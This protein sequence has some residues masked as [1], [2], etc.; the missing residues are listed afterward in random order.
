M[1]LIGKVLR[2][3]TLHEFS[4]LKFIIPREFFFFFFFTRLGT[5]SN[6]S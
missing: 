6:I 4:K 2:K 3:I 1:Y 5:K